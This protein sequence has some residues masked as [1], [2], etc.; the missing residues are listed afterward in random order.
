MVKLQEADRIKI[1][2]GIDAV[3][4]IFLLV[5]GILVTILGVDY[6]N[7]I[8]S[9]SGYPG[10]NPFS[11]TSVLPWIILVLGITTIIYGVKRLVDDT[12]KV[13]TTKPPHVNQQMT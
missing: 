11:S 5:V 13:I 9:Y 12:L 6:L 4:A 8:S 1:T 7:M 10:Y 3:V 2:A